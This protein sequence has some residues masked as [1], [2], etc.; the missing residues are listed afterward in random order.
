MAGE[1]AG[2]GGLTP[3][4]IGEQSIY[5]G[6]TDARRRI[7]RGDETEGDPDARDVAGATSP[8]DTDEERRDRDTPHRRSESA[9]EAGRR[10]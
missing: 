10:G 5:E 7:R 6:E 3:E 8:A 9:G 1:E 2:P 4:E